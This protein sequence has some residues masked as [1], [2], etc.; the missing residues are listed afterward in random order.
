[1][2]EDYSY[3]NELNRRLEHHLAMERSAKA[4]QL[5]L[6][7]AEI[8]H[9]VADRTAEA[10][11]QMVNFMGAQLEHLSERSDQQLKHHAEVAQSQM[12]QQRD[13]FNRMIQAG[14][15]QRKITRHAMLLRKFEAAGYSTFE[16]FELAYEQVIR[17]EEQYRIRAWNESQR[18]WI[19]LRP[20]GDLNLAAN[21][22]DYSSEQTY[23]DALTVGHNPDKIIY[24]RT[25]QQ[26]AEGKNE[27]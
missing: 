21:G 1:M 24:I 5:A 18:D 13:A 12:D 9:R 25:K 27:D 8:S 26:I 23:Q 6:E 20:N 16:A 17:E 3:S 7:S 10:A 19:K 15:E 14:D 2:C 22:A 4:S 11:Q